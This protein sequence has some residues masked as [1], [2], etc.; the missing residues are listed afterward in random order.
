MVNTVGCD[1]VITLNLIINNN[2][3][4]TLNQSACVSYTWN[5]QTYTNSGSHTHTFT[6]MAGC[7]SVVTLILTIY[8]PTSSTIN[9]VACNSLT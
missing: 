1:S 2:T 7:D 5:S 3:V 9:L 6:S 8:Q 4:S